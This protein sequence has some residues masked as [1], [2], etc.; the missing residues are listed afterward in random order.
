MTNVATAKLVMA[1]LLRLFPQCFT[2]VEVGDAWE[3]RPRPAE[4]Y[5]RARDNAL[6]ATVIRWRSP[7]YP[8]AR[9]ISAMCVKP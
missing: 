6:A 4:A 8:R 7:A 1:V 9:V 5:A 3:T 2:T